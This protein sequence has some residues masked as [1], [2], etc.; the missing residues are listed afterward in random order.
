MFTGFEGGL[1][2]I[3]LVSLLGTTFLS[4]GF[5]LLL[6]AGLVLAQSRRIIERADLF[7]IAMLT[8]GAVMFFSPLRQV[9]TVA[10]GGVNPLTAI[11]TIALLGGLLTISVTTLFR[12]IYKLIS[13]FL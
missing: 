1:L 9:I 2:A 13:S 11:L 4:A 10:G 6:L 8:L 5:W 7:V 12:L 3:A